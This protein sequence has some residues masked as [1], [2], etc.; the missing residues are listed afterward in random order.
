MASVPQTLLLKIL[1]WTPRC[2]AI[3][4]S[5]FISVFALD[6]FDEGFQGWK[7]LLALAMHLIPTMILVAALLVAWRW[8]V[9]GAVLFIGVAIL[10]LATIHTGIPLSV[11]FMVAGIPILVGLL[12]LAHWW[13]A[14]KRLN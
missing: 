5:V 11:M 13:L 8:E 4:F 10:Y 9:A 2:L 6:V 1:Y 3:L 7:T 12:F 14:H